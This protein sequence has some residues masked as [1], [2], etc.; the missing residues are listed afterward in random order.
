MQKIN[1]KILVLILAIMVVVAG[2]LT[3]TSDPQQNQHKE[4]SS[5][6]VHTAF[7]TI[8]GLYEY[9]KVDFTTNQTVLQL[10]QVLNQ[11]DSRVALKTK[12]Y[13]GMGTLVEGMVGKENGDENRYWQYTINGVMPQMGA[14]MLEIKEGDR[15]EWH[16]VESE[17]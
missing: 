3:Y 13:S 17:F 9:K 7:I 6:E 10:L 14:D 12:E 2:L 1:K 5:T 11:S 8:E 4:Q 16:F 15:V